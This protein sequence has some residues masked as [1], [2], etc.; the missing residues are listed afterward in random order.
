MRYTLFEVATG[1]ILSN[2]DCPE[3]IISAYITN[4]F[5]GKIASYIEGW[6]QPNI[7]RIENNTP[8]PLPARPSPFYFWDYQSNQWVLDVTLL[9]ADLREKRNSLLASSDW[10]QLADVVLPNKDAWQTYRQQLRD[11]SDQS[12]WPTNVVWPNPPSVA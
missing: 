4:R 10:T 6:Y 12:G 3:D 5:D 2:V 8:V 7:Y 9:E 1:A 11:I